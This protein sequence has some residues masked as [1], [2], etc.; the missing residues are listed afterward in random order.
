MPM[1]SMTPVQGGALVSK[2]GSNQTSPTEYLQLSDDG[3]MS[4]V[5]DPLAATPFPSMRD[6]MRMALRLP[7]KLRAFSL[8]LQVEM[9]LR[10]AH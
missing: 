10:E 3:A 8:P 2:S 5:N 6:A 4:W 1:P 7:A 9:S